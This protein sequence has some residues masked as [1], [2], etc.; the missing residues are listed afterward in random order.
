MK[1]RIHFEVNDLGLEDSVVVEADT[2]EEI[3]AE[4]D[5]ELSKRGGTTSR[6]RGLFQTRLRPT[7]GNARPRS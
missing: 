4:A 2:V 7:T 1:F 3:R 5:K 6:S